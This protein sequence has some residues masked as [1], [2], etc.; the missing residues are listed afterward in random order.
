MTPHSL[1]LLNMADRVACQVIAGDE[2]TPEIRERLESVKEVCE[3]VLDGRISKDTDHQKAWAEIYRT[4]WDRVY[5][6]TAAR[7]VA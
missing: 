1:V 6:V 5:R 4:V 3:R 7:S 2:L